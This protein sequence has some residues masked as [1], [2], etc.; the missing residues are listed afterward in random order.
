MTD[1]E[2]KEIKTFIVANTNAL[3]QFIIQLYIS[4]AP[5]NKKGGIYAKALDVW[6]CVYTNT[7]KETMESLEDGK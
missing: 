7:L 1:E 6:K 3:A 2:M 4:N 5:H